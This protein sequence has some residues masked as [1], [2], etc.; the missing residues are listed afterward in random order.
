MI[1]NWALIQLYDRNFPP[2]V[3][4]CR[5]FLTN[6][7][8]TSLRRRWNPWNDMDSAFASF[9]LLSFTK[10]LFQLIFLLTYQRLRY[11]VYSTGKFLGHDLVVE[12]DLNVPY[13]GKEQILFASISVLFFCMLNL[14]PTFLLLF[15]PF[16]FFQALLSKCTRVQIPMERFVRKF[17]SCYKDG[18]GQDGGRDMRSFARLYFL[19]RLVLFLSNGIGSTLQISENDPFLLRNIIFI[20]T[21]LLVAISRPYRETYVNVLDV[22]LVSSWRIMPHYVIICWLPR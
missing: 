11:V 10:V 18:Q 22:L 13:G 5:P 8:F 20:I 19:V 16:R 1:V 9:L 21:D 2:L 4:L 14:L 15:Y 12:F 3:W 17:N 6:S 7:C